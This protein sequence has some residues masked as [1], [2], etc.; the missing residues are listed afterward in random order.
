MESGIKR[1]ATIAIGLAIVGVI[2]VILAWSLTPSEKPSVPP[3]LT[4]VGDPHEVQK[5]VEISRPGIVAGSNYLGHRVYTVSATLR[6]ISSFPI[7]LVDVK[8]TYRDFQKTAILEESHPAFEPRRPPLEPGTEY[9][10][11]ISFENPPHTWNHR[12]P[13]TDVVRVAY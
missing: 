11:E 12:V 13:D 1:P 9:R 4:E 3:G 5:L 2:G 7:R 8:F 6:N 10:F